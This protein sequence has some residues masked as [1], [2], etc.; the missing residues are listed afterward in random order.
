MVLIREIR[1][2]ERVIEFWF[3]T[4]IKGPSLERGV[5]DELVF[6]LY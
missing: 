3:C 1:N 5:G 4:N 6:S 2:I